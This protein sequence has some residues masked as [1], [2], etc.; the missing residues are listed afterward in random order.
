MCIIVNTFIR[1]G[2]YIV[3]WRMEGR[4]KMENIV[5]AK[6]CVVEQVDLHHEHEVSWNRH[7][8]VHSLEIHWYWN[9][10]GWSWLQEAGL[11]LLC[12]CY[13]RKYR[14]WRVTT[15]IQMLQPITKEV[16]TSTPQTVKPRWQ[17]GKAILY[18]WIG[19]NSVTK[20]SVML[21]QSS[22]NAPLYL[23]PSGICSNR[24]QNKF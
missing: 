7:L 14:E 15:D 2:I 24:K 4:W 9:V 17:K 8:S 22:L 20:M 6:H 3:Q 23:N 5:S 19:S 18:P 11:A 13:Y 10:N 12:T 1:A 21:K 16:K